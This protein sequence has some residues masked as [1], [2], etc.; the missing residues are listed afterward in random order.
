[1]SD[2][3]VVRKTCLWGVSDEQ[4]KKGSTEKAKVLQVD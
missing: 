4:R 3:G 2:R 1:M